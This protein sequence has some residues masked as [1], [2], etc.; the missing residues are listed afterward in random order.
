MAKS[1]EVFGRLC[2]QKEIETVFLKAKKLNVENKVY[3]EELQ[4]FKEAS[5]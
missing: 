3:R 1:I 5:Q 4:K 2:S